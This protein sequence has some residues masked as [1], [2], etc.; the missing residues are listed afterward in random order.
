MSQ[1]EELLNSLDAS[2]ASEESNI[3]IGKDRFITVPDALKRLAVQYDHDIET[4]TFDCPRYWD[5]HDMSTMTIYINYICADNEPG[6]YQVKNVT[7]DSTDSTIM[8]FDWIISK[9]VTMAA[10]QIAFLVCI[11]KT[12]AEGVEKN[13][14]NSEICKDCYISPGIEYGDVDINEIYPDI[15]A[16]W[17]QEVLAITDDI[18]AARENGEFQGEPGVSPTIQV[19]DI[20][21]GHRVTITDVNGTKSFDVKDTIVDGTEAVNALLNQFVYTGKGITAT[22]TNGRDYY[23]T[24]D[25][26]KTLSI[27]TSFVMIP[28]KESITGNPSLKVNNFS[29]K[30]LTFKHNRSTMA[31]S[32]PL[33]DC[34][35]IHWLKSG[36]PVSVTYNGT[37]WVADFTLVTGSGPL[38]DP[39]TINNG[40]TGATNIEQATQN[41]KFNSLAYAKE[42]NDITDID[43]EIPVG[44]YYI[45]AEQYDA[46]YTQESGMFPFLKTWDSCVLTVEDYLGKGRIISTDSSNNTVDCYYLQTVMSNLCEKYSRIVVYK[47]GSYVSGTDWVQYNAS[48]YP[49]KLSSSSYGTTIPSGIGSRYVGRV[50]FKK[51]DGCY[52]YEGGTSGWVKYF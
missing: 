28:D 51:G 36:E 39:V 1:A 33:Q 16:R 44:K 19:S 31:E 15:L 41:L 18:V 23:A 37:V 49:I 12:D 30:L 29:A 40:G 5:E 45:L 24:V 32:Q 38:L 34:E 14:W 43:A 2:N 21:G 42:Y 9:N 10:G 6:C 20:E 48:G 27:G 46:N 26:I 25:S 52:I 3:V 50:F 11:K 22:S 17:R 7:V 35:H 47:N 8:H 13:H 4:V